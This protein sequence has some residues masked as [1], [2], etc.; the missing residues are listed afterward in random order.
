MKGLCLVFLLI[1][2]DSVFGG[3]DKRLLLH[4]GDDLLQAVETLTTKVQNLESSTIPQ[5]QATIARLQSVK[6][7][8]G[9][10]TYV[11]WGNRACPLNGTSTLYSGYTAGS[12]YDH[13]GGAANNLCLPPDPQWDYYDDRIN[14]NNQIYGAEYDMGWDNGDIETRFFG[15]AV[16]NDDVPCAVC[17]S[18]RSETIM[19]PA[20]LDCYPGWTK[21]YSGYLMSGI[22]RHHSPTMYSCVDKA[23]QTVVGGHGD[24]NGR[25]FYLVEGICGSL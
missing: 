22:Y 3:E 20:R 21:E 23:V 5:M 13:T 14:N 11:R 16:R 2:V 9:G 7:T 10:S 6:G 12:Y 24:Q 15:K 17:Y 25:L 8:G 4:T 19:I 18:Q 1:R